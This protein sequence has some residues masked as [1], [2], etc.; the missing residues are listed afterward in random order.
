V[1]AHAALRPY[2]ICRRQVRVT[3]ISDGSDRIE[4]DVITG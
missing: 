4:L 3:P 1:N 2:R